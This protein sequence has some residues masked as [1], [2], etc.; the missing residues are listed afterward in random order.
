MGVP[1]MV[2]WK[3]I[4]LVTMRLQVRSLASLSG[5]WIRH[6]LG[7]WC[8]C[9]CGLD[10]VLLWLWCRPAAVVLVEPLAWESPYA[11]GAALKSK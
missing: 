3:R 8:S 2:Q 5:L 10:P 1:I 9:R 4:R 6:C 7:L 11:L